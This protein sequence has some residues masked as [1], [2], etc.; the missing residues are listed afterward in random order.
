MRFKCLK[1]FCLV[2]LSDAVIFLES[3][4]VQSEEKPLGLCVTASE[5]FFPN[6]SSCKVRLFLDDKRQL[7]L[8]FDLKTKIAFFSISVGENFVFSNCCGYVCIIDINIIE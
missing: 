7:K 4:R 6:D 1:I 2:K 5:P 8:K 3:S